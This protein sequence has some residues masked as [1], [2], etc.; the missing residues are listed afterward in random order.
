MGKPPRESACSERT[1]DIQLGPIMA[2]ISG[3]T[4]G[5]RQRTGQRDCKAGEDL[6]RSRLINELFLRIMNRPPRLGDRGQRNW[7]TMKADH[8]A[9]NISRPITKTLPGLRQ[10]GKAVGGRRTRSGAGGYEGN[11]PREAKLDA[12]QKE[13]TAKAE[14]ELKRFNERDFKRPSSCKSRT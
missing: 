1:S 4:V 3:A 5:D 12:E 10:T 9:V 13:R 6:R 14:A 11:R 7:A 8:A 2:L